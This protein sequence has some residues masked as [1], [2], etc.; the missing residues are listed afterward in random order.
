MMTLGTGRTY[1]YLN[2]SAAVA[3]S[4]GSMDSYIRYRFGYGLSYC[5][6]SYSAF[7]VVQ[8]GSETYTAS[9]SVSALTGPAGGCREIVQ[10]YL[11]LP[12]QAPLVVPIYSLVGFAVLELAPGAPAQAFFLTIPVDD[13]KTTAVDGSRTLAAGRYTFYASGHLPDDP[14]P[15]SNVVTAQVNL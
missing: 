4:G 3:A 13:L 8:S 1:R 11:T 14:N 15:Q 5:T 7:N 6:F 12:Q 10:L 9:G 2:N